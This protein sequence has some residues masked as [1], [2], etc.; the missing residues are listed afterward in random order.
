MKKRDIAVLLAP[1]I[2]FILVV[3][4]AFLPITELSDGSSQKKFDQFVDNVR[5]GK[6]QL[7]SER[8]IE[9]LQV[10]RKETEHFLGQFI[11]RMQMFCWLG[12][13]GML[14][15]IATVLFV[16]KS[17]RTSSVADKPHER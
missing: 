16:A 9:G 6:W 13:A 5:S 11:D 3:V 1:G 17:L 8:W 12:V 4:A 7:T 14:A 2:F 15:Q 10:Q